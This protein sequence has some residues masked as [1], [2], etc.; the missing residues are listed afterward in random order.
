MEFTGYSGGP[1]SVVRTLV[2]RSPEADP[3]DFVWYTVYEALDS[4]ITGFT[5]CGVFYRAGRDSNCNINWVTGDQV[6]G[7]MYT[8]DQYLIDGSPTF[9]RGPDDKIETFAPGPAIATSAPGT[10]AVARCST[11][12]PSGCPARA[13]PQRQRAA[14]HG[15]HELRQGVHGHGFITLN[16]S[17]ATVKIS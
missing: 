2:A 12:R 8:Q 15:R 17:S 16:G 3:L 11:A 9:G 1:N 6:N 13:A 4:A 10:T 5:D 14:A 7:P